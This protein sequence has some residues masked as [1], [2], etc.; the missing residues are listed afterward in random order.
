MDVVPLVPVN[1]SVLDLL[2]E[3]VLEVKE[4]RPASAE[5]EVEQSFGRLQVK[6]PLVLLLQGG[7]GVRVRDEEWEGQGVGGVRSQRE[8]AEMGG[9]QDKMC[10][11]VCVRSRV[12]F[13]CWLTLAKSKAYL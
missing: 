1:D 11:C 6:A 10:V 2:C 13:M 5:E 9:R 7:Q 3:V 4:K 12:M 8:R